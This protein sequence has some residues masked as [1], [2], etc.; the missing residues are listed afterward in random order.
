MEVAMNIL[1]SVLLAWVLIF[2]LALLG[3]PGNDDDDTS[4]AGDDDSSATDD[5][6]DDDDTGMTDD[7]DDTAPGEVDGEILVELNEFNNGGGGQVATGRIYAELYDII[8]PSVG[9]V[10]WNEATTIDTCAVTLY[11]WDDLQTET[12]AETEY[13]SAGVLTVSS[14]GGTSEVAPIS[15]GVKTFY[16]TLLTP[17]SEMPYGVMYSVSAPGDEFPAF[18][19]PDALEMPPEMHLTNPTPS[20][21]AVLTGDFPVQWSGGG[22]D[23][24][25]LIVNIVSGSDYGQVHCMVDNDGAFTIPGTD[26]AQLPGGEGTLSLQHHDANYVDAAGRWIRLKGGYGLDVPAS[27]P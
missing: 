26:L 12:P 1:R 11:T 21:Q 20:Q 10:A 6:D 18:D 9:G 16:Q 22:N 14:V 19:F 7:D 15:A 8:T 23:A 24:V 2:S 13:Q 3:C 27:T 25:F 5:D 17:G 4:P